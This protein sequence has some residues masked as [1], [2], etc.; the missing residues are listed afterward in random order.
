MHGPRPH[1]EIGDL[2]LEIKDLH[3]EVD[4]KEIL[5]G[6]SLAIKQGEIHALMGPNGSGKSTLS[7]TIMGHPRY[8]ITKGDILY[9]GESI[10]KMSP[11]KRA[12]LGLFLSFQYPVEIPGVNMAYF[13]RS[14]M[15]AMNGSTKSVKEFR[16]LLAEKMELLKIPKEFANRYLN[17]GF[18]GGEKK[19]GE[20]LQLAVLNPKIAILDETDSGLDIDALKTVANGINELRGPGIGMLLITHYNRI[21]HYIKPD[22]VHILIDGKI[23]KSGGHELA[24][25]LEET[26]YEWTNEVEN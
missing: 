20:I 26:G 4:G 2:M 19:R 25:E 18:S 15:N 16:Q 5:K 3:V 17:E 9:N 7:Q 8:V 11:D 13:L 6:V 1:K 23:M 14:A 12:R 24:V 21:L 10:L 22:K